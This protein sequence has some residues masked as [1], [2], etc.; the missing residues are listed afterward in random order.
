MA[1]SSGIY[2]P[3]LLNFFS[4][5]AIFSSATSFT[6]EN[7]CSFTVWPGS[8]T[9]NG[10]PL[11]DGGFA[12]APG[13]SSRLQPPP[14]WSGRFWGRTGC[15]FDNSG[16]GKCVTGDCGGALKCSG[17]G[18]PPVSLIEFTLN[19]HDNK[20]FYDIS[21]VDGYNMAVAV[22]AVGG[23]GTCQYAGCVNDLNTNCPAELQMTDSG[24]VVACKS[25]CAAFNTPEYCCTGAHGTPQTCSPTKYS[26]LFKNACPTAY[27]YAYDDATST[28]TCTGADYLITFCP[29]S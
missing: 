14:G 21:L 10:P 9:A 25:A 27:S 20:D 16:S 4:F 29:T 15:N 18:I 8:L 13:S 17:G 2:L 1:I 7:R 5:G 28:M 12:L 6:L 26:Q 3:F 22:K 23:T 19:G 11:G 24:S